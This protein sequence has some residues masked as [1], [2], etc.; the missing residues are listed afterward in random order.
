MEDKPVSEKMAG[1]WRSIAVGDDNDEIIPIELLKIR[2]KQ[3]KAPRKEK[4][5]ERKKNVRQRTE[6]AR[7]HVD[8]L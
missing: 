7:K 1:I 5:E 2:Y 6:E 4:D 3:V 8:T